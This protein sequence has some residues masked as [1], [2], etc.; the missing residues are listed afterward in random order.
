MAAEGELAHE[1]GG[2]LR[3]IGLVA[4]SCLDEDPQ[5]TGGSDG[6]RRA[7]GQACANDDEWHGTAAGRRADRGHVDELGG[8]CRHRLEKAHDAVGR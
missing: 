3:A 6:C 1:H 7:V 8:A 5:F 4:G 2:R